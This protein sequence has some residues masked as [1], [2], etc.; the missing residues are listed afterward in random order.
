[1]LHILNNL[2]PEYDAIPDG[3]EDRIDATGDEK[4]TLEILRDKLC[5]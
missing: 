4:L 1:M 2:N 5:N 3:L